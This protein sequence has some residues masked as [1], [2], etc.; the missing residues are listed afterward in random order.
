MRPFRRWAGAIF[1]AT[2]VSLLMGFGTPAVLP[3]WYATVRTLAAGLIL[4]VAV[5]QRLAN[6]GPTAPWALSFFAW[7][8]GTTVLAGNLTFGVLFATASALG[9]LFL[10][11]HN[12]GMN[13]DTRLGLLIWAISTIL[14]TALSFHSP[15]IGLDG[16]ARYFVG[17]KNALA[18]Y[19]LPA[20]YILHA[21]WSPARG[22]LVL[23]RAA[24]ILTACVSVLAGGS[25]TGVVMVLAYGAFLASRS[26]LGKPWPQWFISIPVL[27]L[28]LVSGWLLRNFAWAR[29]FV[30]SGLNK[31]SDFTRR[32]ST[33]EVAWHRVLQNPWGEGR[34]YSFIAERFGDLSE[35]HNILLEALVTGGW[36]GVFLFL[37]VIAAAMR[38]C[39]ARGHRSGIY[40]L[41]MACLVGT[42]ESFTFHFA[43]WLLL[44]LVLSRPQPTIRAEFVG[45]V[46]LAA[47]HR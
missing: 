16:N 15:E 37:G 18:M 25:G 13:D 23:S 5:R 44:G 12:T 36:I 22:L 28:L 43:F 41:W 11:F 24:L 42:M 38:T 17:G 20:V 29:E 35:A 4:C 40:F 34:G 33:W 8:L 47:R 9:L 26:R 46:D 6:F 30:E 32:V 21:H 7:T 27:H 19:L 14:L 31:S 10:G 45:D 39:A 2:A 3:Q 1:I